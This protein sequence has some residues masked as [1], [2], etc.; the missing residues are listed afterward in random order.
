M[1]DIQNEASRRV[2][3]V[4]EVVILPPARKS[5]WSS[6]LR[7]VSG[8]VGEELCSREEHRAGSRGAEWAMGDEADSR[9]VD[10][11]PF[12][13]IRDCDAEAIPAFGF[14]VLHSIGQHGNK[15]PPA[16]L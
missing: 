3:A 2:H 9:A 1:K 11:S 15:S 7:R 8:T 4:I 16:I 6:I 5:V 12:P 13:A 10:S 14:Q